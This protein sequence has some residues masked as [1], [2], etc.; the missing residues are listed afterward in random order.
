MLFLAFFHPCHT[1]V[2][3]PNFHVKIKPL[4]SIFQVYIIETNEIAKKNSGLAKLGLFVF[5]L[6]A[7]G[8]GVAKN[9]PVV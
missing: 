2:S 3:R 1:V 7:G 4:K 8:Q 5:L 6:L 9:A